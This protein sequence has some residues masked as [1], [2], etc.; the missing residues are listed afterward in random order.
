MA[1]HE[2]GCPHTYSQYDDRDEVDIIAGKDVKAGDE[3][4]GRGGGQDVRLGV[5]GRLSSLGYIGP[6]ESP[7]VFYDRFKWMHGMTN[8]PYLGRGHDRK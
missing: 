5:W 8:C 4:G 7:L 6:K 1:N 2:T 3:V